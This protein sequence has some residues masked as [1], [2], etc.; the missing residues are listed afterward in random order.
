MSKTMAEAHGMGGEMRQK[1]R[2]PPW[3]HRN[4]LKDDGEDDAHEAFFK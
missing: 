2:L 1:G 4:V 3:E